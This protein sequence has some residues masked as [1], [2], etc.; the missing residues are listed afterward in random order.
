MRRGNKENVCG[1]TAVPTDGGFLYTP[2]NTKC[3]NPDN[4]NKRPWTKDGLRLA[5]AAVVAAAGLGAID[6]AARHGDQAMPEH[7]ETMGAGGAAQALYAFHEQQNPD[8]SIDSQIQDKLRAA[9]LDEFF[10]QNP[11]LREAVTALYGEPHVSDTVLVVGSS[12]GSP[13]RNETRTR[14]VVDAGK[15]SSAVF[16]LEVDEHGRFRVMHPVESLAGFF[17]RAER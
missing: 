7:I 9:A 2:C 15:E 11:G 16:S 5:G 17:P 4:P 8:E 10:A 1:K 12:D 13:L 6:Q 3:M 14:F